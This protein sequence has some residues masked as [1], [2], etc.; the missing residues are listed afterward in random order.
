MKTY[1]SLLRGINVAN[2]NQIRMDQLKS[3]YEALGFTD[4]RTYV[5]SGNVVFDGPEDREANIS[6]FLETRILQT[7]GTEVT[8]ILRNAAAFKQIRENNPFLTQQDKD[9]AF[10]HVTFLH[11]APSPDRIRNLPPI[12][13]GDDE[14]VMVGAE[15]Y[16][17]CPHGY[18]R[19]KLTNTYFE[20]KLGLPATTRNWRT[21]QALA[22][23]VA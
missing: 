8:V 19:T 16:I 12:R 4:V 20:R 5:Q 18:G 6:A 3:T 9:P 17:F 23:M 13:E 14:F 21:V 2:H 1:I 15:V 10:L 22:Q 7:F 11:D